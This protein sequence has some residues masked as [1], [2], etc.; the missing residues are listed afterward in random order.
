M[1]RFNKV[2]I[3]GV[4]LIGGSIGL[5]VKKRNLAKEVIGIFRRRSTLNKALKRKAVDSGTLNIEAGTRDADLIILATP[6]FLIPRLAREALK[7]AKD[8]AIMTDV[9][10]TKAWI[11]AGIEKDLGQHRTISFVGSHPMAGS[12]R[13]GVESA[14]DDLLEGSPCIV[15]KTAR[16]DKDAMAKVVKFW[17]ALGAKV[18]VMDPVRHDMTVA[19]VSHLPHIVAF[20]LAGAVP[21]GA[22]QYAAEGFGDVTRVA[23]SDP[24]L[25]AE[26]FLTNRREV[27][28]SC[29]EFEKYYTKMLSAIS[30]DNLP[31]MIGLLKTAKYKRD[32][33]NHGKYA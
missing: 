5:A 27:A 25:W 24:V 22:L 20:S 33:F 11:T 4:G 6:V 9:G 3:I 18:T 26:I 28:R 13:A 21:E 31:A 16:T 10:S 1:K 2:A 23:S 19:L 17:K 7:Y 12:E 29:R 14:R 30:G 8:G 32:K 15:T